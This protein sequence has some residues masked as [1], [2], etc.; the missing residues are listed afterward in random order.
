V[1]APVANWMKHVGRFL[2]YPDLDD[3]QLMYYRPALTWGALQVNEGKSLTRVFGEI[4]LD[5]NAD[6]IKSLQTAFPQCRFVPLIPVDVRTDV[7]SA[8]Q[9]GPPHVLNTA[10]VNSYPYP[11]IVLDGLLRP[12]ETDYSTIL[13]R[14]QDKWKNESILAGTMILTFD[15][16]EAEAGYIVK[17]DYQTLHNQLLESVG[18]S[19]QPNPVWAAAVSKVVS[20]TF[21]SLA[22]PF[23]PAV[24]S[25]RKDEVKWL[26]G[27]H[28]SS[29]LLYQDGPVFVFD[30]G[31][32]VIGFAIRESREVNPKE[33]FSVTKAATVRKKV[34]L[35]N[36]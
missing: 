19:P 2:I 12:S 14:I 36:A 7:T 28:V 8:V 11:R 34:D 20:Q 18:D 13:K 31:Q 5:L 3:R 6:A 4:V 23:D 30:G 25:A 22:T 29:R 24:G 33:E 21:Q 9:V 15:F 26:I 35:L 1:A 16:I 10:A 27:Q 17:L 32:A